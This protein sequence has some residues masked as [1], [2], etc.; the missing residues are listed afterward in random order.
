MRSSRPFSTL[1][2]LF[3]AGACASGAASSATAPSAVATGLST[4]ELRR[5]MAVFA[6]DSFGGRETGTPYADKAARWLASR[7]T[8]LG[9]E[10]GGDSGYFARVP[11][12]RTT[13]TAGAIEVSGPAGT[14]SLRAGSDIAFM[15]TLGPGAPLPKNTVDAEVVF[16]SYGIVDP[17]IK[18]D[19]YAGLSVA[20]KV[21]VIAGTVPPGLDAA[22]TKELEN[23]Q[24]LFNRLGAAI[25]R[26]A[27]AV[28]LLLPDSVFL[29]AADQFSG[30]QIQLDKGAPVATGGPRPLP[31][32]AVG[33]L[34]LPLMPA[35]WP[36]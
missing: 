11:M 32:V 33:R 3:L 6:S 18:R 20:G 5:D 27:A 35:G 12:V 21:V 28:V 25:G 22:K 31:L 7:L 34:G 26:Q 8:Q 17:A 14:N 29:Q 15:T 23:P 19:D 30:N 16:A 2:L 9:L 36:S 4:E 10:P 24:S 13:V 1:A